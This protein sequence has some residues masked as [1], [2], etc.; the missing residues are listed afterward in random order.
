MA[1]ER[2][3]K[4]SLFDVVDEAN[5]SDK[6]KLNGG[7]P[8]ANP[9]TG[10]PYSAKYYEILE[11]R[12]TLP[13]WQQ[14]AEFL[15]ILAKNQTMILVGETGSGKTTQVCFLDLYFVFDTALVAGWK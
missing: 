9:Y 10:R 1:G 7:G 11:K 4:L 2:K 12:R 6:T 15:S 5:G 8:A 13:V 14:K 3:R